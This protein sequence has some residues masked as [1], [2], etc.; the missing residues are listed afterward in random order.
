M[1]AACASGVS[2]DLPPPPTGV[3]PSTL[4]VLQLNLCDSGIAG[5]FTGR[6][7]DQAAAVIRAVRPEVVT[8]NEVCRGDV[9]VLSRELSGS[10]RGG[11]VIPAFETVV[12]PG[13]G[14]GPVRCRNGQPYGIGVLVRVDAPYRGYATAGGR[15]PIQDAADSEKR[16]WLCVHAIAH[17]YAC[18]TH[19]ASTSG[20]VALRQC[21]YLMDTAIPK[22]RP[23]NRSAPV[24]LGADL[25]LRDGR[26]PSVRSC[27][28]PGF[29]RTD[30]G[31]Q[32]IVASGPLTVRRRSIVDM[33]G[34]T[35]HPGLLADLAVEHGVGADP[36]AKRS[37]TRHQLTSSPSTAP[38]VNRYV[39]DGR[40][41]HRASKGRSGAP[42]DLGGG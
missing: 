17:V 30:D 8:L 28:P 9:W 40:Q 6:S 11:A 33:R 12:Q 4:R 25:N 24:I 14:D 31:T 32:D 15:Y 37:G 16:A 1:A 34:T 42:A 10:G 36:S 18:T 19:L 22:L 26:S 3:G 35:D 20:A 7:V 23:D 38:N 39:A 27:M 13:A 41:A 21:R 29:V 5:C 2:G